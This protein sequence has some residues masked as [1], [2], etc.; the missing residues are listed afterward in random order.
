MLAGSLRHFCRNEEEIWTFSPFIDLS[1][2]RW[3]KRNLRRPRIDWQTAFFLM[4]I[5]LQAARLEL[6]Y[7]AAQR[8]LGPF[9]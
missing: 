9:D 5:A 6:H 3:V 7:A 8:D 4:I 1:V 2:Y